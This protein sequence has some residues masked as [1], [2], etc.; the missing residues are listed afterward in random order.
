MAKRVLYVAALVVLA[1]GFELTFF[2]R[3]RS[4]EAGY[5]CAEVSVMGLAGLVLAGLIAY[6][7]ALAAFVVGLGERRWPREARPWRDL[8]PNDRPGTPARRSSRGPR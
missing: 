5:G 8:T 1:A 4:C 7:L 3:T 6:L 2:W